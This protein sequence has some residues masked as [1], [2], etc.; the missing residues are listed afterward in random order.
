MGEGVRAVASADIME[1]V[2]VLHED[3]SVHPAAPIVL[4]GGALETALRA[5]V[6]QLNLNVEERPSISA[7]SRALRSADVISK[8]DAKDVEQ[9]AGLRNAAAHGNFDELS[10]ERAGLMEQ[11]VN[12]FLARVRDL[13]EDTAEPA[14]GS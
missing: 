13:L 6:E 5:A 2:R 14:G 12:M 4:A 3:K 9:M 8:Q 1:Q 11:Q 10:R 7:Y